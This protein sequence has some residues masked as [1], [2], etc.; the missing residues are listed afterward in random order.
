MKFFDNQ[1]ISAEELLSDPSCSP[2]PGIL[3]CDGLQNWSGGDDF[4]HMKDNYFMFF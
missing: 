2:L 1:I 4:P 3:I